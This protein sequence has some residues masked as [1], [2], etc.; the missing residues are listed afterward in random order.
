VR[1]V[2]L[3]RRK[4]GEKPE[5]SKAAAVSWEG[6]DEEL[7]EALRGLRRQLAEER[8]V[9]P[10][11]IFSDTTLRELARVRPSSLEKMRLVYGVGDT[12]LRDFG[13]RFLKLVQEHCG[14]RALSADNPGTPTR[15]VELRQPARPSPEREQALALFRK[16]AKVDEVAQQTGLARSTLF[17]YLCEYIQQEKPAS[18][19]AWVSAEVYAAVAGAARRVD[20]ERLKPIFIALGERVSYD[21]IRLVVTHLTARAPTA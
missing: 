15:G 17:G 20:T 2:Q 4:K 6:V 21:D 8:Q 13:E 19:E 3:V 9:P 12:K 1:L 10:Y 7:F 18:I 16:G 11:V 14:R 5:K